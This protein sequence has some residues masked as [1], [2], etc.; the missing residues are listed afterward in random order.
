M[1]YIDGIP[2]C[3]REETLTGTYEH[4]GLRYGDPQIVMKAIEY[5]TLAKTV[6]RA[7][8]GIQEE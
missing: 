3:T 6:T 7:K 8:G 5:W 4:F 2:I 1:E